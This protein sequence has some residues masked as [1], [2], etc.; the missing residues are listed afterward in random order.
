MDANVRAAEV[1]RS[2]YHAALSMLEQTIERCPDA[3]WYDS[4]P[5]NRFWHVAYHALIYTHFYLHPSE[6]TFVP[7]EKHRQGY[8]SFTDSPESS[9]GSPAQYEP[10]SREDLL[11]YLAI[12]R[13]EVDRQID[14]LDL[15]GPSGFDWLPFN[16]LELQF[17]N[18]RH[19]QQHVGELSG[20]LF[21]QAGIEIDWIGMHR[22]AVS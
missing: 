4:E 18:I 8:Q 6:E 13:Q 20:R 9:D 15:A 2:H 19:I 10:Y 17:Y 3:L 11:A 7:W 1:I 16:K 14:Q 5:V 12:C 21:A 22:P